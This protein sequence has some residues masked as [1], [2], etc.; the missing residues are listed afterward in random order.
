MV[1]PKIY[2]D[3]TL[4]AALQTF[5]GI[6]LRPASKFSPARMTLTPNSVS[7]NPILLKWGEP[8]W[9]RDSMY[10]SQIIFV[11]FGKMGFKTLSF[12]LENK[13]IYLNYDKKGM[14]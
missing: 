8:I 14:S 10:A 9:N 7:N 6:P 13:I 4:P 1:S 2:F 5:Y 11:E 12:L 3:L